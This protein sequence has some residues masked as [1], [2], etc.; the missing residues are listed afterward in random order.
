MDS[1]IALNT[2]TQQAQSKAEQE[3][4][5]RLVLQNERRLER[6]EME[7]EYL[8]ERKCSIKRLTEPFRHRDERCEAPFCTF[9]ITSAR[10]ANLTRKR[11]VTRRLPLHHSGRL[12]PGRYNENDDDG[13]VD[14]GLSRHVTTIGRKAHYESRREFVLQFSHPRTLCISIATC[15]MNLLSCL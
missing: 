13:Y 5:K 11:Y 9:M 10:T 1:T 3:Q 14:W 15:R 7:G 6:S 2:R 4:L 12:Q 8:A